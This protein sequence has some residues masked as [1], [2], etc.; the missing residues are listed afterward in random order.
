MIPTFKQYLI[1]QDALE[2]KRKQMKREREL[3]KRTEADVAPD[4]RN[5]FNT[6]PDRVTW[7]PDL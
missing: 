2:R 5:T 7:C 3:L 4:L 1:D 6:K